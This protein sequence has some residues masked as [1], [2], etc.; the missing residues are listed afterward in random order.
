MTNDSTAQDRQLL[1]DYSRETRDPYV[2]RLLAELLGHVNR[3]GFE[4]TAGAGGGNT[5]DL[6]QGRYAISYAHTPDMTRTDHLA[7]MVHELTHVAVGQAYDSRM[8][9]FPVPPLS[10][11]EEARVRNE[12]PGREEDFQNAG[13]RRADARRR[14]A[15]VDL[16]VGNVQ[17]L[18]DELRGSGLPAGRQRAVRSKLTDH[19]RA[20]PYHEYDGVLSHVLVW[21]DL[22]GVDRSS[23]FYRSLTAMVAQAA[24]WRAAGDITLPRRRRGLFRRMGRALARAMGMSRRR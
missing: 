17:R 2:Q 8:L 7:V 13:L 16:V 21:A 3:A 11:A 24:D 4:R 6:G 22:D 15:F 18:L 5:R 9:N 23:A 1:H 10:A 20:R 12:T 14:D 19:M